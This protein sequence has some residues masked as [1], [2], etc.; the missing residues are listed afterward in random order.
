MTCLF[1][2]TS[3]LAY[4]AARGVEVDAAIPRDARGLH[5]LCASYSRRIAGRL[6]ARIE[7]GDL[8]AGEAMATLRVR[9]I[10][11]DELA[12]FDPDGLLLLNVNTREDYERAC[13]AVAHDEGSHRTRSEPAKRHE[14]TAE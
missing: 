8:R 2:T 10:G 6:K 13:R 5:P 9:E 1:L 4:V 11:P 12:L 14:R 3:F 7:D